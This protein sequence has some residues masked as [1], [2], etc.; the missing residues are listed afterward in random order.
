MA[1][2]ANPL[3]IPRYCTMAMIS[4]PPPP[5]PSA[6]PV[7]KA[8]RL[9]RLRLCRLPPQCDW[10][11]LDSCAE[12]VL[13]LL[14]R[15]HAQS[16]IRLGDGE[17]KILDEQH[18]I[19]PGLAEAIQHADFLG[20]RRGRRSPVSQ[21]F[22]D[23]LRR[24]YGMKFQNPCIVYAWLFQ[25]VPELVGQL[26]RGKR[27]LW[28]TADAEVIVNN[29][30]DP[31]FRDFYGL[32]DLAGNDW[33]NAAQPAWDSPFPKHISAQQ[34][35]EDIRR[36]LAAH[37]DFDLALVGAG[38]AGKLVCHYIKTAL[39]KSA[40]DVGVFMSY[41]RGS[42]ERAQLQPGLTEGSA[43]SLDCLVWAPISPFH[44]PPA[45]APASAAPEAARFLRKYLNYSRWEKMDSQAD[46]VRALFDQSGAKS[47]VRID[48]TVRDVIVM[49]YPI[50]PR[51]A[52][53]I[54]HA[55]CVGLP[56][57]QKNSKF[58][59]STTWRLR[60]YHGVDMLKAAHVSLDV[61]EFCPELAGRLARG[62]RVLWITWA[63]DRIVRNLAD[64]DFSHFYGLNDIADNAYLNTTMIDKNDFPI[65]CR[66]EEAFDDIVQQL[67]GVKDFDLAL[68]EVG[69]V[70]KL[71]CHHI[72]ITLGKSAIDVGP[73]MMGY[74]REM[75]IRTN[76]PLT[77]PIEQRIVPR[78]ST[79]GNSP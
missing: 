33:I 71:V 46:M 41:V 40:I 4:T 48:K 35:F 29:L 74:F 2:D 57:T 8:A 11:E 6:L 62:K 20:L 79:P 28:I 72:K 32:H 75:H 22:M 73:V 47:L 5:P 26:A 30:A 61:F 17:T 37:A 56:D 39:G 34:A 58:L 23:S 54:K 67:A 50:A 3:T 51:M 63:A 9:I 14:R 52:R 31:D 53:V 43:F 13:R 16:L 76:P 24:D 18:A 78:K 12:T 21:S 36:Q 55:D 49:P 69:V 77:R 68:V 64:P 19:A 66:A 15:P 38:V 1:D 25:F 45:H 60:S 70:G 42:R 59:R 7:V 27:V 10:R 65:G 44:K